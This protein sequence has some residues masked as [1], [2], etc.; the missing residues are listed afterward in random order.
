MFHEIGDIATSPDTKWFAQTGTGGM[1][2]NKGDAAKWIA[3]EVRDGVRIRVIYQLATGKVVT[4]FP[5][6]TVMPPYKP[7]KH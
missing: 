5:D 7:V 3:Y 1:Y 2:T 4:A 6:N